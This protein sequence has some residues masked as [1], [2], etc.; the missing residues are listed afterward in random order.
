[1]DRKTRQRKA[2]ETAIAQAAGPVM[3]G[4]ILRVAIKEVKTMNLSTVYRTLGRMVEEGVIVPVQLPGEPVRYELS[5]AAAAHHHHFQCTQCDAVYDVAGC[6][7]GLKGLLPS[8]FK[9]SRH[10]ITLYGT[11]RKCVD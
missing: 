9:L 7:P 2:I 10:D 3:P 4:D 1:M 11:C 5:E 6:V 8:G